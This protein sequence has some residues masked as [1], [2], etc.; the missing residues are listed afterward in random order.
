MARL[1]IAFELFV[2][3]LS[4]AHTVVGWKKGVADCDMVCVVLDRRQESLVGAINEGAGRLDEANHAIRFGNS[5]GI[6]M[7]ADARNEAHNRI[8]YGQGCAWRAD[9]TNC[10]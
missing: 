6:K 2:F 3:L 5:L 8:M 10:T 4:I 9:P 7:G 1:W